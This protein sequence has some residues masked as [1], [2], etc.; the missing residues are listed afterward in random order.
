[1]TSDAGQHDTLTVG[2]DIGG[3]K[4]AAGV[5]DDA[6]D[7]VARLQIPTPTA[8]GDE[9]LAAIVETA[10]GFS[11][12]HDVAAIGIGVAGL[13][14]ERG[15]SVRTASHLS[16]RNEP[17]RDEV[18]AAL[19]LPVV[20]DNDANAGGWA[21]WRFGA[22]AG[23]SDALFVAVGTGVGGAL[24]VGDKLRR[25][26]HGAAGEIGH[27]IVERDGR[28]CPCGSRGCWEQ[29]A[30]GRAFMRLARDAGFEA[31][32]G[33]EVTAAAEAGDRDAIKVFDEIGTWLGIGIA[34]LVAVLDPAVVVVGGGL[35][36]A[37]DLLLAPT[38]LAFEDYLTAR[39]H[40][41][42]PSLVPAALGPDAGL[43]G[44]AE[45]ARAFA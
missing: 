12:T 31:T 45:L 30:S 26:A 9:L 15:V 18:A 41:P 44:A 43:I 13:V 1:M 24:I 32:H 20:V 40:R 29:Y 23:H 33:S 25:G 21:E 6:G 34:G 42:E 16:L 39:E 17:L 27:V 8:H 37:G 3:T 38:R 14:D 10:L 7:I 19:G 5:V 36:A 4:M 35:S 22:A 28:S 11:R 2:I